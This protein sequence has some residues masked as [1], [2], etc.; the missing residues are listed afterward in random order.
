MNTFAADHRSTRKGSA[1]R[2]AWLAATSA[3][4]TVLVFI[5]V[6]L[7]NPST[8]EAVPP[9]W[10]V[11]MLLAAPLTAYLASRRLGIPLKVASS[12]LV[13]LPQ[14]PL[15]V[16]LSAISVW[17]DVQRGNLLAGSGEE[18]MSYGIGTTAAF[19]AGIILLI[20]VAAAAMLGARH[21][22]TRESGPDRAPLDPP[23]VERGS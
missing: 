16:V 11:A 4:A 20:L 15:I 1:S 18:S 7:R 17:L 5:P 22:A 12:L 14:L 23:D 19:I 6:V 13:G 9:G 21:R 2:V 10:L 3:A 8:T